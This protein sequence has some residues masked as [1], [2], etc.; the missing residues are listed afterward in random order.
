MR[1]V[2]VVGAGVGGL[3]TAV[4]L[5]KAGLDVTVL[6]SHIYPGGCA[7]TF[8]YQ[9]YRFDAG[10]TLAAG[11]NPGGPMDQIAQSMDINWPYQL[12]NPVMRTHLPDGMTVDRWADERRW[13][14]RI[15]KFG[16]S[17]LP[18]W[19]WQEKTADAMWSL[20]ES[21]PPWPP[22]SPSQLLELT[23]K[24]LGWLSRSPRRNFSPELWRDGFNT[25]SPRLRGLSDPFQLFI[26]GQLIISAQATSEQANALYAAS[27]LDL[28]RRGAAY[29]S[30]GLG[31]L[32]EG[33]VQG[34][35]SLGGSLF[36]RHHVDRVVFENGRPVAVET[37]KKQTIPADLIIFNLPPWNIRKLMSENLPPRLSR[38][39]EYPTD[40]WGA[41]TLYLGVDGSVIPEDFPL[42]HQIISGRPLGETNSIF[43]SLSPTWDL[44]RAPFGQ[45]AITVSTHTRLGP[46]WERFNEDPDAYARLKTEYSDRIL[47]TIET[48]L[49]GIKEASELV[50][51]GTPLAFERFTS[52]VGGW[53]GGFPQTSLFNAWAPRLGEN[54]W[55][56]GDSI[57]PGQSTAAVAMGGR[58]VAENITRELGINPTED[59]DRDQQLNS[60]LAPQPIR[61]KTEDFWK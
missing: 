22:Q 31:K 12:T 59:W 47:S 32:A 26:D 17:V 2:V 20:A 29:I 37:N 19:R 61:A 18:F 23:A 35:N 38:L 28:P 8:Y 41:Y 48:Q 40:G 33:L 36:Y 6:E 44:D 24:G 25:I 42:H 53:V 30:G 5:A 54:L 13:Q 11:F 55:M 3:T 51:P 1:K 16:L 39:S 4:Y 52:R 56:V 7:G 34:L 50:L 15:E 60:E 57:F 27:A 43:L 58:R 9:G 46:W 21:R 49:P 10:A 14:E 45:R